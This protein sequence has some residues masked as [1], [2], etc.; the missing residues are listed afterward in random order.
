MSNITYVL[1]IINL[2]FSI[3]LVFF[4]LVFW[5][6]YLKLS[7]SNVVHLDIR[8]IFYVCMLWFMCSFVETYVCVSY[9]NKNLESRQISTTVS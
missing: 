2:L 7:S 3:I 1:E 5:S 8:V 4:V 6:S 9:A